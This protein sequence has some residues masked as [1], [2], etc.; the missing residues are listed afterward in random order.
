MLTKRIVTAIT[1]GL[2]ATASVP[3]IASAEANCKWVKVDPKCW[4]DVCQTKRVC[5]PGLVTFK[6]MQ[7]YGSGAYTRASR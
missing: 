5:T 1:L 3:Q 4:G 2:L 7:R 6:D